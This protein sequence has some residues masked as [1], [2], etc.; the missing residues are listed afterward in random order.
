MLQKLNIDYTKQIVFAKD[1]NSFFDDALEV[2]GGKPHLKR[3]TVSKLLETR[4]TTGFNLL[5]ANC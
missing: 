1:F 3:S 5:R 4:K 2:T